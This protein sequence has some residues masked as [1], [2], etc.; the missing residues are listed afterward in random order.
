MSTDLKC[1]VASEGCN[2][3]QLARV[4]FRMPNRSNRWEVETKVCCIACRM[5]NWGQF[6]YVRGAFQRQLETSK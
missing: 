5:E 3:K 2:G 4:Q 6:R 1:E